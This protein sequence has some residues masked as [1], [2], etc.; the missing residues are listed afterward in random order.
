MTKGDA[1]KH[2]KSIFPS[3][4]WDNR[5]LWRQ[6]LPHALPLAR[7]HELDGGMS[8]L[9]LGY[10]VGRCLYRDG[11]IREAV[12]VQ[13]VVAVQEKTLAEDHPSRLA[14]QHVLAG[15]YQANGQ[16]KE[17]IALLEH[18]VATREKTLAEEPLRLLSIETIKSGNDRQVAATDGRMASRATRLSP[19]GSRVLRCCR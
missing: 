1:V 10:W 18:V 4:E 2:L 15:A 9:D 12:D 17:A 7:D 8:S 11:R 14:S 6:Y 16:I 3:D 19:G 13:A 5:V